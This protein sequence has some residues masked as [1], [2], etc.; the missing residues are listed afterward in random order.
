MNKNYQTLILKKNEILQETRNV[1][2]NVI[3]GLVYRVQL[4]YV[5]I[6]DIFD[7]KY[8][9]T[10]RMGYSLIPCIY[11]VTDLNETLKYILPNNVKE[12]ITINDIRLKFNSKIYQTLISPKKSFFRHF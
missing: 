9:P 11:E 1:N 10:K 3:K 7:L 12:S 4:T 5:E 2:Y 8:I 6:I